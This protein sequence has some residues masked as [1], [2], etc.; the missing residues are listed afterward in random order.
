[1]TKQPPSKDTERMD[2]AFNRVL[3]AEAQARERVAQCRGEAAAIVSDATARA[4]RIEEATDRRM[5]LAH[6]IADQGVERA[7]VQLQGEARALERAVAAEP[8]RLE[9]IVQTLADEILG[10]VTGGA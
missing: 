5:G 10:V 4:R 3:A 8:E 7:M 6:Q 2:Q 9:R 1:M